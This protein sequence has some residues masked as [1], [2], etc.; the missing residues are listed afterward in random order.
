MCPLWSTNWVFISQKTTFFI[1]TAVKASY[2]T[3]TTR[4]YVPELRTL[5]P[6]TAVRPP[7][8]MH[9]AKFVWHFSTVK[10]DAAK[11]H[12]GQTTR[13]HFPEMAVFKEV[14]CLYLLQCCQHL[15][16]YEL[17]CP[18]M[19]TAP[20]PHTLPCQDPRHTQIPFKDPSIATGRR[21]W[22]ISRWPPGSASKC[23]ELWIWDNKII[24]STATLHCNVWV[25]TF[26]VSYFRS[27]HKRIW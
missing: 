6:R 25:L 9:S 20:P 21:H 5:E 7:H 13:R 3:R 12:K 8:S 17:E 16:G 26:V 1:V 15:S 19:C 23:V 4:C 18:V 22:K 27:V 11:Y 14:T 2:I 24:T 10:K